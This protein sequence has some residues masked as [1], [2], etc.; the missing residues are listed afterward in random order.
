[1]RSILYTK[2]IYVVSRS[3]PLKSTASSVFSKHRGFVL[4]KNFTAR[5]EFV[6]RCGGGGLTPSPEFWALFFSD[7]A[8]LNTMRIKGAFLFLMSPLGLLPAENSFVFLTGDV[9]CAPRKKSHSL[10]KCC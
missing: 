5:V 9:S 2:H 7:T 3:T 6:F 8:S 10:F 4:N 1:M